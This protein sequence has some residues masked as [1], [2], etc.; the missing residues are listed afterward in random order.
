[1]INCATIPSATG[2]SQLE[3]W[4]FIYSRICRV[5]L[6]AN[7][8]EHSHPKPWTGKDQTTRTGTSC[9]ALLVPV[10]GSCSTLFVNGWL[11]Q[12]NYH[13][14]RTPTKNRNKETECRRLRISN[15]YDE[16]KIKKIYISWCLYR[17][18]IRSHNSWR[19]VGEGKE[20]R[21]QN[22]FHNKA[23]QANL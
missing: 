11:Q 21:K 1:M 20:L 13:N 10:L 5:A 17:L 15:K 9:H 2:N 16:Q 22:K 18:V 19:G 7:F 12:L 3:L 14:P 23:N 8:S 4:Y 6:S